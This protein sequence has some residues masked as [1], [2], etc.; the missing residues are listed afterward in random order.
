[1]KK[2]CTKKN[3]SPTS[4]KQRNFQPKRRSTFLFSTK[5]AFFHNQKVPTQLILGTIQ[6]QK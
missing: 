1:M 6:H 2:V 3:E 5:F 4:N